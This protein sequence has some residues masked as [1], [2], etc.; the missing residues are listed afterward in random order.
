MPAQAVYQTGRSGVS[1]YTVGGF[2]AG[3]SHQV[4][5]HFAEIVFTAA[6]QRAFNI[7]INGATVL[8]NF[9]IIANAGAANKAIEENFAA[10]ANGSG[11]IV[12]Q[13]T[14]ASASVPLVNW[15]VVG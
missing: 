11:Q 1:T 2:A 8:T 5:L 6:R 3:S 4:Q 7:V 10:T 9:D 13:F 14:A 12:I 15:V